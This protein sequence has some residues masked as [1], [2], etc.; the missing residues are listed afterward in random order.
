MANPTTNYS[1]AMPT[2]TDLVKDLPADFDIFGQ[3]VDD[4]IKALNPETTL[5][6]ISYRSATADTNTR[7]A[8]G[9][10]GH[11]LTVSGGVPVW[12]APAGGGKVL[13]VVEGVTTTQAT[14][15]SGTYT[16]TN[17]TATITPSATNSKIL[18]IV[19]A[20]VL[21]YANSGSS[22]I[23]NTQLLRDATQIADMPNFI[24]Q[25]APSFSDNSIAANCAITKLDSPN[26][27]SATTYKVQAKQGG[28]TIYFQNGSG[29]SS[30]ILMEIGA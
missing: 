30:I 23:S 28:G 1:F 3:A 24:R 5:G 20:N 18:V 11:I 13:Q 15:S 8:I 12:A 22:L 26:T 7:L 21:V 19:S 9:S 16:D 4:R 6:D 25:T 27:T 17:I 10:T 14:I 2:N 29:Q